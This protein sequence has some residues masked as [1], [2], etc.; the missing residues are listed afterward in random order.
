V[1]GF[2]DRGFN[3]VANSRKI[4]QSAEVAASKHVALVDGHIGEPPTAAKIV[5]TAL[6]HF[7]HVRSRHPNALPLIMTH[8]W[9]GSIFELLKTIGPLSD[10]TSY[11]GRAG[12]A[13]DVVIPS[14]PGF[15]FSSKPSGTGWDPDRSLFRPNLLGERQPEQY[16]RF[17]AE[18]SGDFNAR[19]GDRVSRRDLPC[20]KELAPACLSKPRL[21][22]RGR[23]GRAL[24]GLGTTATF[25]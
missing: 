10:P 17:G 25:L 22:Q 8:G 9:P 21:F 5:E 18:D 19:C 3:V 12:D 11:G 20:T 1:K 6:S 14:I 4:T 7:I 15:G 16:E 2:V 24:R 13:F 23:Q